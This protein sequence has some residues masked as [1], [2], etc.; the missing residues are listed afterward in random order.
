MR[1]LIILTACALLAAVCAGNA[2][3]SDL[4]G[5]LAVTGRIGVTNPANGE[6]HRNGDRLV[7][8]TDAGIIGGGGF[9]FGVDENLAAEMD[10]TR[11]SF[12][13]SPSFGQTEVT[14]ISMG[15]QYRFPERQ[16]VIP[17]FGGGVDVLI[18]D[19]PRNTAE[20]VLGVHITAGIDY[21][22]QRNLSWTGEIKGVEA[23]SSD[24]KDFTG[25]R[26]GKFDPSNF[27]CTTGLRFYFN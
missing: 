20:T 27:S 21:V 5:R 2:A 3:A 6:F 13:A 17:Y 18:N 12:Y 14:N 8:S 26:V 10:I 25:S 7:V 19:L 16:R 9:L 15:A 4:R 23:F 22:L 24:V 11:S 1:K